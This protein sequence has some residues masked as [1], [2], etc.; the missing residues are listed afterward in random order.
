M[1][2][3]NDLI[4]LGVLDTLAATGVRVPEDIQVTGFDDTPY[5]ALARPSLTTVRQPQDEIAAQ[6]VRLLDTAAARTDSPPPQRIAITPEL[7]AR[8]STLS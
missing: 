3:G 6:A 5:A 7:V 2:C 1:I 4:A 8:G